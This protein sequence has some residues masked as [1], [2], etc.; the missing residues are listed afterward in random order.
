MGRRS[1]CAAE[2][3]GVF[4]TSDPPRQYGMSTVRCAVEF[5]PVLERCAYMFGIL[6]ERAIV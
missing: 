4:D 3:M 1:K 2:L 6:G 5:G